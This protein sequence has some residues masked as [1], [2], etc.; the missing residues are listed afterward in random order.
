MQIP[1]IDCRITK[2]VAFTFAPVVIAQRSLTAD[3]G[4]TLVRVL[5]LG[6]VPANSVINS[7]RYSSLCR[8]GPAFSSDAAR[9]NEA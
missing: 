8:G 7:S 3:S 1:F 9:V 2:V 4:S 5:F 6:L